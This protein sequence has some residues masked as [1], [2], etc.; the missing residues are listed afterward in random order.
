MNQ[1]PWKT[2][3]TDDDDDD[4]DDTAAAPEPAAPEPAAETAPPDEPHERP[5]K[6]RRKLAAR[7]ITPELLASWSGSVA[8]ALERGRSEEAIRAKLARKGLNESQIDDVIADAREITERSMNAPEPEVPSGASDVNAGILWAG[9]G[10]VL[11]LLT[12]GTDHGVIF[13]GA[14]VYGGFRILR[15]VSR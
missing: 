5:K 9:G 1:P 7:E 12:L 6:K 14:I 2:P 13:Y 15:G 3:T 10:L 8:G 11:T 4:D